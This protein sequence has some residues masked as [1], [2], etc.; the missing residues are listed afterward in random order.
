MILNNYNNSLRENVETTS[1]FLSSKSPHVFVRQ[2]KHVLDDESEHLIIPY[3]VC[4]HDDSFFRKS[5]ASPTFTVI[6]EFDEDTLPPDEVVSIKRT[7]YAGDHVLDIDLDEL[8]VSSP[9]MHLVTIRC[10]QSNGVGSGTLY[11]RYFVRDTVE[12]AKTVDLSS[13]SG[14]SVSQDAQTPSE[15]RI[16]K[17]I[18]LIP[19]GKDTSALFVEMD[20]ADYEVS[21]VSNN[22]VFQYIK[23]SVDGELRY[24]SPVEGS[25]NTRLPN[26][27]TGDYYLTTVTNVNGSDVLLSDYLSVDAGNL[28]SAV[29]VAAAKNKVAL[30]MLMRAVKAYGRNKLIMPE[31]IDFVFDY[32]NKNGG[33]ANDSEYFKLGRD[34]TFFPDNFTLDLNGCSI[35]A[36]QCIDVHDGVLVALFNNINTHVINGSIRGNLSGYDFESSYP[37]NNAESVKCVGIYASMFCSVENVEISHSL[38]YE[39]AVKNWDFLS[40]NYKNKVYDAPKFDSVGYIDYDGVAHDTDDNVADNV[41]CL[42]YTG[43]TLSNADSGYSEELY[44]TQNLGRRSVLLI[45][46]TIYIAKHI[47]ETQ[48]GSARRGMSKELFVHYYD[49]TGKFIK[50]VKVYQYYSI[51]VPYNAYYI[52]F[53]AIGTKTAGLIDSLTNPSGVGN[54]CAHIKYVCWGNTYRNCK[55][56]NCRSCI[57]GVLGV[58]S[59][60]DGCTLWNIPAIGNGNSVFNKTKYHITT[61]LVD[62]E[63]GSQMNSSVCFNNCEL[64]AKGAIRSVNIVRG[65]YTQF[66]NVRNMTP[67]LDSDVGHF[68]I[69]DASN[70]GMYEKRNHLWA[71]SVRHIENSNLTSVEV[72]LSSAASRGD[73]DGTVHVKYS[74]VNMVKGDAIVSAKNSV[75]DSQEYTV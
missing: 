47:S 46:R 38:G 17:L 24:T 31:G 73:A 51:V 66:S 48:N 33:L 11:Y 16:N 19:D 54:L 2:F 67:N 57:C 71:H 62:M 52:R 61:H 56:H 45:S 9:G 10:I 43:P 15:E 75:I 13:V 65:F 60:V 41:L 14:F 59:L 58:Q 21:V 36:L 44:G 8:G 37:S 42:R 49:K 30:T 29:V 40:S 12:E 26:D 55:I 70:C 35:S 18:T 63:D 4:D 64:I 22:G 6:A 72:N 25:T 34:N 23:I 7:T 1:T 20:Y 28:P 69:Y 74:N 39:L 68:F 53:S 5:V 32:H 3:Y 27:I 50:T